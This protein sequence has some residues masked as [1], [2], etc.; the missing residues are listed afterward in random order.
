VP[1]ALPGGS[2]KGE[3]LNAPGE[4]TSSS[5][6]WPTETF[7]VQSDPIALNSHFA[8]KKHLNGSI[9]IV[10]LNTRQR[11]GLSAAIFARPVALSSL[12]EPQ[13]FTS[14]SNLTFRLFHSQQHGAGDASPWFMTV[15]IAVGALE[16]STPK[17]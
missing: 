8:S 11:F 2:L 4:H 9:L 6:V 1:S 3:I 12:R 16:L 7:S 10:F 13:P 17:G 15:L 5:A 14:K